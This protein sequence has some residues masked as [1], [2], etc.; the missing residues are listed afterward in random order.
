L[1]S[2]LHHGLMSGRPGGNGH[3]VPFVGLSRQHGALAEELRAAFE[4]VMSTNAFTLGDEVE[5]FERE[6]AAFCEASEC[7]GVASGT[8]ALTLALMAAGIGPGDEVVVPGHTFIASALAV[9]HAG[10]TPVFC[11]V[12][13]DTGLVDPASAASVIG[14]RTAAIVAVHLY[15]QACDM[16]S[17]KALARRHDLFLLEDAAQAHGAVHAGK[18]VG[19][20][21]DAAAFSFYPSKN[22]GALGD[23]GAVCTSDRQLAA[24]MRELRDL[25][26]GSKGEHLVVGYNERLDGLQ[27]ALLRVKLPHLDG[28]NAA[29]RRNAQRL[30]EGLPDD[31]VLLGE[32]AATPCVYHL[33]PVRHQTRD[34]LATLLR[35]A[36]IQIGFHYR[37]AAHQHAALA[38]LPP[39]T[40]PAELP[41]AEAWAGEELSLPM[42][43]ELSEAELQRIAF[44]CRAACMSPDGYRPS[45]GYQT[46]GHSDGYLLPREQDHASRSAT[47]GPKSG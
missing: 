13:P 28:W 39:R 8:A 4:R 5:A 25:G 14:A 12:E 16:G 15:G 34:S 6:F 38:H 47:S 18:R 23:G 36:G 19:S 41:Q 3:A 35:A 46:S 21:G 9:V 29:R 40:R 20:L 42:F 31:L 30:R 44:A 43:A 10:A 24:R 1:A 22:L 27:A 11:D 33:F 45:D 26:Q 2:Q 32:R 7:V 17:L 37:R